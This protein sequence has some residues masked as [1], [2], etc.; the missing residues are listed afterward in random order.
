MNPTST[1]WGSGRQQPAASGTR[2][3]R[4]AGH[5]A[6]HASMVA[7][8]LLAGVSVRAADSISID[9]LQRKDAV[10]FE[11]EIL[12]LLQK[13]CLACHSANEKQGNLVLES[14]QGML[15]G[16]DTGP[17]IVPGRGS[18]SLMLTLAAHRED[19]IM[20]PEDNDVAAN[21]LTPAELGL[22]KLWIDQGAQGS[23]GIDSLSPKQWHPLPPGVHPVQAIAL[24]QDGQF[25]ACSRANQIFLYHVPTGQLITKLSDASLDNEHATGIAHRDLVQS[26]AFNVDG[27]L[28]ASGGFRE[29]KLWRRPRDVQRLNLA[30]GDAATALAVSPERQW[31]AVAV[32]DN[33]IRL[34]RANDGQ[35]G[36]TL[37]GHTDKVTSLRF[38]SDGKRIVSGSADQTVRLW[39]V[40]D[41]KPQGLIETP[42]AVNAIELVNREQP[43]DQ[44]PQPGQL[45][46]SGDTEKMI[47]VW[48]LP[49]AMPT[50]VP[51]SLP[52]LTKTAT[53][54]DG[55]LMAM[56][57]NKHTIR[58]ISLTDNEKEPLGKELA[59]WTVDR[60]VT[61]FAFVPL[62]DSPTADIGHALLTGAS[63][64]S[65]RLWSLP[66]HTVVAEWSGEAESTEA[67]AVSADGKMAA[68]GLASGAITLW[69]LNAGAPD[70]TEIRDTQTP[71]E[72]TALSP[73]R[74]LLAFAG[75]KDGQPAA[76]VRNLESGQLVATIVGHPSP[77]RALAFSSDEGRLV[78]GDDKTI[79][80][81]DLRNPAQ[82]AVAT[83]EVPA[84]VT[85]VAANNDGSQVLAGFADN[86][87]RLYNSAD[88]EVAK[89]FSGNGGAIMACGFYTNQPY[90]VAADK[91]VRFWNAADGSQTR[92]FNLP[93]AIT[94]AA[95]STDGGHL[96]FA[97][98]DKQVRIVQ[99][100]NG[101]IL[102]TLPAGGESAVTLSFSA[103]NGQLAVLT[104]SGQLSVWNLADGRLRESVLDANASSV[105]FTADT[106]SLSIGEKAGRIRQQ[107]F[108]FTR[109]LD[110]NTKAVTAMLFHSN[111]QTLFMTAADGSLRGYNTQTGQQVFATSHGAAVADLAISP[112]EQVLA[113]AGENAAVRLWQTNGAA[114]GPQQ[115]TGLPGPVNAVTFSSD[116]TKVIAGSSGEKPATRVYDLQSGALLQQFTQQSGPIIGCTAR[117]TATEDG[118]QPASVALLAAS[119]S[120]LYR[121]TATPVRQI[122]GHT[123]PITSLAAD[124]ERLRHIYSSSLD[125]SIRRWN[126]DNG[127]AVG[128]FNHG[129][130][131]TAVAVSPDGQRVAAAGQNA[132]ARL[133][134]SNGQQIAEMRGDV[135]RKV[136]HTRA[137]QLLNSANARLTIAKRL[138]D[139]AEKDVPKKTEAEKTLA[140]SL[141]E[142]NKEATEKQAAVDKALAEKIAAEK[143]AIAASA[144]AKAALADQEQAEQLAKNATAAMQVAQAKMTQLQQALAS[145]PDDERLQQLV[146]TAQQ[147]LATCQQESQQSAAAV[148][149]PKQKAQEMANAA[150]TAATKVGDVQKPYNDAMAELKTS[151]AKQN[152]LSQQHA[153]AAKELTEAKE[154]VPIRKE[155]LT[156]AETAKAD[157]EKSVAAANEALQAAEQPLHS[158]AFSPDGS[159]LATAGDFSSFHTWDGETGEAI[160]AF[161]G[162][163]GPLRQVTFLDPGT[164]VSAADDQSCRAWEM[165]PSWMLERTIG[166]KDDPTIIT[167][168]ATAVDINRDSTQL[169]IA[170]GV[171]SRNG[172]LQV[173]NIA[174]GS[175]GLFLPRA[176][177]DVI[178]AARFSPDGKQIASAGADKYLRTFDLA[179]GTQLRRFEG[180]TNYVLGVAW[181][182]DGE[183]IAT[184]AAD[185][186]IKLWEAETGD[187]SRT[188]NQQL[189]K[190]VTAVQFI[191]DTNNIISSS[192]DK[193]VRIHNGNNGAIAR[194]F[195]NVEAWLHCVAVTP[196]SNIVAAGDASGTVTIWNGTNGQL[197]KTLSAE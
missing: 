11:K 20:P 81:W 149:A 150:N 92:T 179:S 98:D 32:A 120:G 161:A 69:N 154:L 58:I 153:L 15:Q 2:V 60:G 64:G 50:K 71:I 174:D 83:V 125:G 1:L 16:G 172:E 102:H 41:G 68:S 36:P 147:E 109:H 8:V 3:A 33:S 162:H 72:I 189:S 95:S 103:D 122:T 70:A 90:S 190:H 65:M 89:E 80:L 31:I 5:F 62:P 151:E 176:H 183:S 110:G 18:E 27:D 112:N 118:K 194:N 53:S 192:G 140:D 163:S 124:P 119:A 171:P 30:V 39:N 138:F 166:S 180:H 97:G 75:S 49:D 38:T 182:S 131:V 186:T 117:A 141:A 165:N 56:L 59:N 144:A 43:N 170:G 13:N 134:R 145:K 146:A 157:A 88:G 177:D 127:Q 115:V 99:T 91:S 61:S 108:R 82:G 116:S 126:L 168:R 7:F 45:L 37:S 73:T 106:A 169:L 101:A 164:L 94:T 79:Q 184:S 96:A 155:S 142:A 152:L 22:L 51:T 23:S 167:H 148:T 139:E 93:V 66:Q 105:W 160:K 78:S 143:A 4:R 35:P 128:Q 57:D 17:A 34:F 181:K 100:D 29:V 28:L 52:N 6:I 132:R 188:I 123:Q 76:F 40:A 48:E 175:R 137:Q 24:T 85:A 113:T 121:L 54:R 130:P 77:I 185:N 46:V 63:D 84:Q 12:P 136:S 159:V 111:G 107:P 14:P 156:R 42:V 26:L 196:D 187:Q 173:F 19:P 104:K 193:R 133:F 195:S 47:R 178:Y 135:R 114:F 9:D 129:G 87:L 10:S 158:I 55:T 191:G 25:V 21:N 44:N 86:A 67:L 197:L 74:K